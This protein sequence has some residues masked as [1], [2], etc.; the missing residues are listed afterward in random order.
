VPSVPERASFL[1]SSFFTSILSQSSSDCV[2][3]FLSFFLSFF[4]EIAPSII[5]YTKVKDYLVGKGSRRAP[6]GRPNG[7]LVS[8]WTPCNCLSWYMSFVFPQQWQLIGACGQEG[9]SALCSL[10]LFDS[11]YLLSR[12][13]SAMIGLHQSARSVYVSSGK[14]KKKESRRRVRSTPSGTIWSR[15]ADWHVSLIQSVPR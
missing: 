5:L 6:R 2:L 15:K 7:R 4:V 11:L 10:C 14:N 3:F 8:V 9:K 1:S 13:R 12:S